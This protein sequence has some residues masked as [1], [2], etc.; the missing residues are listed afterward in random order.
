[1]EKI[2]FDQY[3]LEIFELK[4]KYFIDLKR[5][6][7]DIIDDKDTEKLLEF[8][9]D[10]GK[11]ET[12]TQGLIDIIID[13]GASVNSPETYNPSNSKKYSIQPTD[14]FDVS[15]AQRLIIRLTQEERGFREERK[16]QELTVNEVI[17][18]AKNVKKWR[19]LIKTIKL[20]KTLL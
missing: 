16:L 12:L 3:S 7:L 1:L 10:V 9:N 14:F 13:I 18:D 20:I 2:E 4:G 8:F 17:R 5:I 6:P 19:N 15:D 11:W